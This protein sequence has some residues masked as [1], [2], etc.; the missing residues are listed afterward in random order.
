LDKKVIEEIA[1]RNTEDR[2][3]KDIDF[4]SFKKMHMK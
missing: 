2:K 1:N 4:A 3:L